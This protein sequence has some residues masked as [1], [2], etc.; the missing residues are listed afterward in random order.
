MVY[1]QSA[2]KKKNC[3]RRIFYL[4]KLSFINEEHLL[5]DKQNL[6]VFTTTPKLKDLKG[7]IDNNTRGA[8]NWIF[9]FQQ[10]IDQSYI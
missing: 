5:Q 4:A 9:H 6:R 10:W 8:G 7:E 1:I 2:E 3:Q